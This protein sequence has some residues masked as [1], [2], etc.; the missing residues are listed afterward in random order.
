MF[1]HLCTVYTL[2]QCILRNRIPSEDWTLSLWPGTLL[3][4]PS[5]LQHWVPPNSAPE[6]RMTI[7][8]NAGAKSV[9]QN[10]L[11]HEKK[12][13]SRGSASNDHKQILNQ[14]K[15]HIVI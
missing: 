7:S 14:R 11:R 4:F 3:I 1:L 12:K 13:T 15:K 5:W 6:Q 2:Y 9:A 10:A 8:F